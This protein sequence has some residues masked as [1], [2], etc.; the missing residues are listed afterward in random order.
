MIRG[1]YGLLLAAMLA[2]WPPVGDAAMLRVTVGSQ[3]A[4]RPVQPGFLGL[5]LE[6]RTIPTLVGSD[7][8][9]GNPLFAQL[10]G[11]LNPGASPI[12]RIGGQSTDRSWWPVAH[13]ARPRGVTYDLTPGWLGSARTLADTTRSRLILGVNL[14]A[15]RQRISQLEANELLNGLGRQRI[16][17]LEIGNEPEIYTLVPWYHEQNGRA[18]PWYSHAGAAV[19][20]RRPDYGPPQFV[21][22]FSRT[23]AVMPRVPIAGPVVGRINWLDAFR[24]FITTTSRV[25]MVTWHSY[26]LN[27]CVT[28]PASPQ[29]PTVPNLLAPGA[30]RSIMNG[31]T[32]YVGLAHRAG[33]SFRIDEMGSVTCNG[34]RGVSNTFASA[35]WA[36]D[37]LFTAAANGV[38][39]VNLH[40][41]PQSA[42]GLFDFTQAGGQ[43][44]G[45]VHPLYYGALMFAQ[46]AP[47]G[48]QLLRVSSADWPMLRAWATRAPDHRVRVLLINDS[49]GGSARVQ[50]RPPRDSDHDAASVER[51]EAPSAY[52]TDGVSIGG[53]TFGRRT[54]RGV[55][56]P[57]K[58]ES[59]APR[60]GRYEVRLPGASAALLTFTSRD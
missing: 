42:N 29:Y 51:L 41:F 56:R 20:A 57:A 25:R 11:E 22:E 50:V 33:A 44:V 35:L 13:M 2:V 40:T 26:G 6:Y 34:R 38:D 10:L 58:T 9:T 60:A 52:S 1:M 37:A 43:W 24:P 48:A 47:A 39:G 17:A 18:L 36:M 55:L 54:T 27:Q 3:A 7:P 19:Y 8:R 23:L 32:P 4:V 30:S 5:A 59:V 15:N 12:L 45:E 53:R 46:A 14:E 49:L 31:A 21:S 16:A 28:D